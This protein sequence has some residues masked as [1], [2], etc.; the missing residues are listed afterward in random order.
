MLVRPGF[1]LHADIEKPLESRFEELNNGIK[2]FKEA[3]VAQNHWD[4]VTVV[5]VS[6]FARTLMG[7]T[8]N[9]SDHAWGG[10]Y[11]IASGALDGGKML[12]TFPD[13][14][15]N[16]GPLVFPPGIVIPT[17]SWEGLWDPIARWFGVP[18]ESLENVLPNRADFEDN[19]LSLLDLFST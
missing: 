17:L 19:L 18:D 8:G 2:V 3:M 5:L 11:F 6:E 12:G 14:L 10:N 7:N 1:D 16:D 15:S 4:D 9:G 13:D